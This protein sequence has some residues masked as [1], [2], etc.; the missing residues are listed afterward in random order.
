MVSAIIFLSFIVYLVNYLNE[1][2][3]YDRMSSRFE[4]DETGGSGRIDIYRS[5]WN[6]LVNS[7]PWHWLIGQGWSG[8]VRV[9][10]MS[11]TCHNDFLETII[12]F[13]IIGFVLYILLYI[14]LIRY[15]GTMIKNRHPY[16]PAM[17]ASI[18][19]F[20]VNSMV[21]HILIYPRYLMLFSLFWGFIVSVT[22]IDN[23]K[24]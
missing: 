19:I 9:S 4:S 15:C 3:I 1:D 23:I 22:K 20:F 14:E 18:A 2:V 11:V 16:A 10:G 12:D 8:S 5:Y 17:G 6:I 24:R 7:S 13:G 21:S